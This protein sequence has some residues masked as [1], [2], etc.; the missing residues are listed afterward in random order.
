MSVGSGMD[1]I[2]MAGQGMTLEN[3]IGAGLASGFGWDATPDEYGFV[4]PGEAGAAAGMQNLGMGP[5]ALLSGYTATKNAIE[6][7]KKAQF[8]KDFNSRSRMFNMRE[9]IPGQ[10]AYS[11]L[12]PNG[13]QVGSLK[14]ELE[15]GEPF[16]T[17]DGTIHSIPVTA[18]SHAQGGVKLEL[19]LGTQVLGKYKSP[20]G[21]Q[22]KELGTRLSKMQKKYDLADKVNPTS[23][24]TRTAGRMLNNINNE[25]TNLFEEQGVDTLTDVYARGGTIKINPKNRGKFNALKKRT[26]KSTEELTHSKNP[27]TRK[28]AIFAQNARKWKHA[29][30]GEVGKYPGGGGVGFNRDGTYTT[31]T[32][33]YVM[34]SD[35]QNTGWINPITGESYGYPIEQNIPALNSTG[36][37]KPYETQTSIPTIVRPSLIVSNINNR[38]TVN[39]SKTQNNFPRVDNNAL[40]NFTPKTLLTPGFNTNGTIQQPSNSLQEN[41]P[42]TANRFQTTTPSNKFNTNELSSLGNAMGSLAPVV[43]NFAQ[44][45]KKPEE[46]NIHKFKNPYEDSSRS[47]MRSRR[48]NMMP[49]LRRNALERAT[50]MRGLKESGLSKGQMLGGMS[51]GSMNQMR[52][53]AETIA[54]SQNINNQYLGEQAQFDA[55]LGRDIVGSK[56]RIQDINDANAAATRNSMATGMSQLGQYSQNRQLMSNQVRRDQQLM[57]LLPSLA[58]SFSIDPNTG[59]IIHNQSGRIYTPEEYKNYIGK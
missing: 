22:F 52:A 19:P 38:S 21:K 41:I 48:Y 54:R 6:T 44:G 18:R 9:Q 40:Y 4:N 49:E 28:R 8:A 11:Q 37:T 33:D 5:L 34:P 39:R 53:N 25:Y 26:G 23:I 35:P 20:V 1:A 24:E 29:Y 2:S 13:G 12:M 15:K 31:D 46:L 55:Q 30:G 14:V 57:A 16:R 45:L 36:Y 56:F 3:Q 58:P 42:S 32:Y 17:P 10:E 50:Y 51:A 47:L 7:N 27:L 43:Y 59:M